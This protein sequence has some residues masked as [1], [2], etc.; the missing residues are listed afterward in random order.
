MHPPCELRVCLL[1]AQRIEDGARRLEIP[2]LQT[3]ALVYRLA[4]HLEPV[5]RDQLCSL[6]WPEAADAVARH[7]LAL[8]LNHLL[9][10]LPEPEPLVTTPE[11]IRL[12]EAR[13]RSD[14]ACFV[15][16]CAAAAG[17]RGPVPARFHAPRDGGE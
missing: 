7:N 3:S 14:S 4:V 17:C 13:L 11:H 12:D 5:A 15:H 9:R 1:A 10:A 16:L 8:L 2:R 6:F